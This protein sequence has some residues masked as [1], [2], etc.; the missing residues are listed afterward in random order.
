MSNIASTSIVY[1]NVKIGENVI[2]EDFCIIGKPAKGIPED[3]QSTIIG[4]NSTIRSHTVIY[5]GNKIGFNFQTGHH[6]IVR[7]K[8]EIGNNVSVGSG[9]DIEHH[10]VIEDNV[11]LHSNV[12]LPEFSLLKKDSWIGPNVVFTNARYPKSKNVKNNLKGP[13]IGE[14]TKI[15]ANSTLLPGIDIGKNCLIGAGSVI[16]KDI[17][18]NSLAFGSPA[19]IKGNTSEIKEYNN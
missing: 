10:T 17:A 7:E 19:V 3:E 16:T 15:G 14:S 2:I 5:A 1:D 8:N 11:R 6:V 18:D 4:D 12:F 13:V 9:T